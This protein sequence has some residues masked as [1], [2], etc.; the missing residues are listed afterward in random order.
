VTH[1]LEAAQSSGIAPGL[2]VVDPRPGEIDRRVR[3]SFRFIA[4]GT[5]TLF[6]GTAARA[7]TSQDARARRNDDSHRA[8]QVG[9]G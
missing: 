4:A 7:A 2:H 8:A 6:L 3:E 5:D 9:V 1:V